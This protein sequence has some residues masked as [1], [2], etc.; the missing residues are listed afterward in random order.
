MVEALWM[1]LTQKGSEKGLNGNA[2][3]QGNYRMES[4]PRKAGEVPRVSS[5]GRGVGT[6]GN[7]PIN[8]TGMDVDMV[9]DHAG[10]T[11]NAASC[12]RL[13]V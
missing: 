8:R 2:A 5:A 9:G 12:V 11:A 10:D 13:V 1:L 7:A 4:I 6:V 3:Q